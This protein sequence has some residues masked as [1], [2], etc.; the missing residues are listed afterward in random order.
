MRFALCDQG[1]EMRTRYGVK[2]RGLFINLSVRDLQSSVEFF[3]QL[4]FKFD[5]RLTDDRSA[6]MIVNDHAH[7]VLLSEPFFQTFTR[8]QVCD[9]QSH[10]EGMVACSCGSR[11]EVDELMAK[12]IGAGGKRAMDPVDLGFM[13][14]T[15][16]YDLDGHHWEMVWIAPLTSRRRRA[17]GRSGLCE[18]VTCGTGRGILM[19]LL[20]KALNR[21]LRLFGRRLPPEDDP[22]SYVMAPKK[23]RPPYRSAAAVAEPPE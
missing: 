23:P 20:S 17:S 16:F 2:T 3:R 18:V 10:T 6:C 7:V 21:V 11:A 12:A 4:G 5:R 1:P 13:Y 19:N 22:Y 15:S 9:R 8:R 14:G